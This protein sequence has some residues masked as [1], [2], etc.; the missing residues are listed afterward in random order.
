MN[1]LE[2]I[3]GEIDEI[4]DQLVR[5]LAKRFACSCQV[6]K[7][8]NEIGKPVFDAKREAKLLEE[9]VKKAADLGLSGAITKRVFDEILHQSR[10]IQEAQTKE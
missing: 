3:R 9:I 10:R 2:K 6:A 5:L 8:K 1:E 4:D 7:I